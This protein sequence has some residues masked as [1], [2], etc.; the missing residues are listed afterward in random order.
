[1][2]TFSNSNKKK[3][4][5][6]EGGLKISGGQKQRIGIARALYFE[7]DILILDESLNAI[8]TKTSKKII[9][10]ILLNYPNLTIILVTHSIELAKMT[11]KIYKIKNKTLKLNIN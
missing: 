3:Q 1:M 11:K 8:D 9:K 2:N 5:L 10:N 6:G 7:R 4:L